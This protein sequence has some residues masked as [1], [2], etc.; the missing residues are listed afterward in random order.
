[1]FWEAQE[2]PSCFMCF[3]YALSFLDI[4]KI[5]QHHTVDPV[6]EQD[7]EHL[8]KGPAMFI[9]SN[10]IFLILFWPSTNIFSGNLSFLFV[11]IQLSHKFWWMPKEMPWFCD[12]VRCFSWSVCFHGY[13]T[14]SMIFWG[15]GV[16]CLCDWHGCISFAC[17]WVSLTVSCC[18][19][20]WVS[21]GLSG[22]CSVWSG[23]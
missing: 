17:G 18:F 7:L 16:R 3:C 10:F 15:T 9:I 14:Y 21:T 4:R 11:S 2:F 19:F 22:S 6:E 12:W 13:S 5:F 1:M 8:E 23:K 20:S